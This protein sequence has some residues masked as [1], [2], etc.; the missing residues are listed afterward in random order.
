MVIRTPEDIDFSTFPESDGQPMAETTANVIQMLDLWWTLGQLFK[1]Q[2]RD[3]VTTVG[4]NQ[5]VYYNRF[6]GRDNIS[7][8]VYVILDRP[9]PAPP[10]WKTWIEGKFPDV[11][12][13]ITSPSTQAKDLSTE[14]GGKRELYARLGAKEYYIY[15]PQQEM[16]P[17]FLGFEIRG[18]R[19]EPLPRLV[20]GG[21]MSPLMRTELRPIAMDVVGQRPAGTWLRVID[22]RT[23][24]QILGLDEQLLA[25]ETAQAR[26]LEEERA[27]LMAEQ[28]A[29]DEERARLMAEQHAKDEERA[30]LAAEQHAKDEE[31]A[32]LAADQRVERAEAELQALRAT[33]AR[34]QDSD[35]TA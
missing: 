17:G 6:N 29:K 32:R 23:G 3:G 1:A 35:Y 15:D 24:E 11:V 19:L 4:A 25:R 22:P 13:E 18:G 9:P 2:G 34:R 33:L 27:R 14:R 28:H 10:S 21:I 8:D 16:K 26:L 30:R 7:P 5:F 12:F 20:G 31:R